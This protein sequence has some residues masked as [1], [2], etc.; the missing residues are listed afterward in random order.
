MV[1][2]VAST[3]PSSEFGE[4]NNNNSKGN[5]VLLTSVTNA[6]VDFVVSLDEPDRDAAEIARKRQLVQDRQQKMTYK[7]TLPLASLSSAAAATALRSSSSAAASSVLKLGI[8]LCQI[9]K[10]R[11]IDTSM[12]LNLDTLEFESLPSVTSSSIDSGDDD[13]KAMDVASIQRR[14][15]GEFQGVVV[16]SVEQGSAGWVAGVRPG[17][18]LKT[19]S[20]TL[21]S[22]LWPKSTLEGVRSALTSRK[23]VAESVQFEF[24]RLGETEDNQFELTLTRPIGLE[25]KG[26][27][28]REHGHVKRTVCVQWHKGVFTY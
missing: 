26:T 9:S 1:R 5:D 25:L 28:E 7:V 11:K 24:Q 21:G 23:A 22:Q 19:T 2:P 15:D 4:N 12:Q 3:S 14:I 16:A 20:A 17:D 13:R 27:K 8:A 18:I 10:G 6:A